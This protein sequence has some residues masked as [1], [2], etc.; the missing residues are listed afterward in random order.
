MKVLFEIKEGIYPSAVGGMEIFNYYFIRELSKFV[1]V[2]YTGICPYNHSKGNFIKR[3]SLRP[4]KYLDPIRLGINLLQHRPN[5]VVISYSEAHAVMW[6]LYQQVLGL[7]NIPYL[8]VI[9]HGK[10]P[11]KDNFRSYLR[12]FKSAKSVV[13]VSNSIKKNYD[14]LFDI[15][16]IVIPPLIPFEKSNESKDILL[17]KFNLPSNAILI[18]MVGTVKDMKHQD[19]LIRAIASMHPD[20]LAKYNPIVV[21]AG[22]GPTLDDM[23]N[24]AQ[25]LNIADRVKFLGFVPKVQI[26]EIMKIIDYYVIASDYEGTS[27]SLLEAMYNGK[28]IIASNVIGI[29]DTVSDKECLFFE[30]K[31]ANK[32]KDQ[33]IQLLEDVQLRDTISANAREKYNQKYDYNIML[34]QYMSEFK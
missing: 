5:I 22:N 21:I 24:L 19:T 18:G 15:D 16:C 30:V 29:N 11:S 13:A 31:N 34:Q 33:I 32:L 3:R 9:H 26:G 27:V 10:V 1:D 25:K 2:S 28:P 4:T 17:K 14:E 8:V 6:R 7:L 20:I 12:F 23:K